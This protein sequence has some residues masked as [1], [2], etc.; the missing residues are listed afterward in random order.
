[1]SPTLPDPHHPTSE[2]LFAYR[3]GELTAD[4]RTLIE[5]HVLACAQCSERLEE[6]SAAEAELRLRP[7]RADEAYFERMTESVMGKIGSGRGVDVVA[8][9]RESAASAPGAPEPRARRG[10]YVDVP[11]VDRRRPDSSSEDLEPRRRLHLPWIGIGGGAVAAVAVVVVAVALF[12]RQNEWVRAPRPETVG[13]PRSETRADSAQAKNG[14]A[15]GGLAQNEAA[16]PPARDRASASREAKSAKKSAVAPSPV[17]TQPSRRAAD[18]TLGK[19]EAEKD[20]AARFR[21]AQPAPSAAM[22]PEAVANR[23]LA[24]QNAAPGA[25]AGAP[26]PGDAYANVLR[27]YRLPPVWNPGVP[28]EAVARAETD[29]RFLYQMGRAGA[30]S[31]RIRLYLAEAERARLTDP[32]NTGAVESISHHYRRAISLA[33]GDATLAATAR[34]RLAEFEQEMTRARGTQP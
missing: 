26:P 15:S 32:S 18:A 12:Q 25:A 13:A 3:D 6:M 22:A 14:V 1:M 17:E 31:A 34:R 19:V 4:R 10:D 8:T 9:T 24:M 16:P 33:G 2:E 20:Q 29:L 11:R 7:D 5:A 28:G 21:D 23:K 27:A 30:D